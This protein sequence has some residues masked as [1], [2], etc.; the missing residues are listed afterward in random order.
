[1][2]VFAWPIAYGKNY[3][4]TYGGSITG[5]F[6]GNLTGTLQTM[7]SGEGTLILPGSDIYTNVLQLMSVQNA[8]I[9]NNA[10]VITNIS[11]SYFHTTQKFPLLS[12]NYFRLSGSTGS[13][14]TYSVFVNK[15]VAV[16]INDENFDSQIT[17]YPN[18]SSGT[19]SVKLSNKTSEECTIAIYSS[20]GQL[21]R[22]TNAGN[23]R[24]IN[25]QISIKELP[26]GIYLVKTQVGKQSCLK[27]MVV[28]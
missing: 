14:F 11:Y 18:P 15:L 24:N 19:F 1:M 6:S 13:I 3:T 7:A 17:L 27:K 21:V 4:D 22:F 20:S 9:S 5:A 28:Q 26:A 23:E 2:T 8:T 25:E 16:G 12:V 10:G